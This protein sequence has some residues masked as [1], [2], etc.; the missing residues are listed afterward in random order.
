M[1]FQRSCNIAHHSKR[2]HAGYMEEFLIDYLWLGKLE[3][4]EPKHKYRQVAYRLAWKP[5]TISPKSCSIAHHSKRGHAGCM[6]EFPTGC[7]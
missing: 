1:T 2:G 5:T 7:L 4:Y 6:G 3:P